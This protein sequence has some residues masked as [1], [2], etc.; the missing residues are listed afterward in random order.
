MDVH[1]QKYDFQQWNDPWKVQKMETIPY[2]AARNNLAK[3]M[4]GVHDNH[5]PIMITRQKGIGSFDKGAREPESP[6]PNLPAIRR[7]L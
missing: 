7:D 5:E 4:Y 1:V 6:P 2:T 3:I